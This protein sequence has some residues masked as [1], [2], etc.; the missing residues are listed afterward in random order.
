MD[1]DTVEEPEKKL[2]GK[3]ALGKGVL[4]AASR[5]KHEVRK[6]VATAILAAFGFIIALVWKDVITQGV[7]A[8]IGLLNLAGSGYIFTFISALITTVICVIGIIYFSRWS[9]KK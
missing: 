5:L 9:E 3:A 4:S 1:K 6:N 2:T 8:L 7:A